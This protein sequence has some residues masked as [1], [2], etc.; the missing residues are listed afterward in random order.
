MMHDS[1]ASRWSDISCAEAN[2][3]CVA[4]E[5]TERAVFYLKGKGV[6]PTSPFNQQ[7]ILE[8]ESGGKPALLGF[9]HSDI[10]WNANSGAWVLA[11]LK[12]GRTLMQ[13]L[14]FLVILLCIYTSWYP[15][16]EEKASTYY[17]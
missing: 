9:F 3:Y 16:Q 13:F 12:V 10:T 8:G 6:C 14:S 11:S 5:Y 17:I 4:C 1:F 7:Y 15:P 2:S